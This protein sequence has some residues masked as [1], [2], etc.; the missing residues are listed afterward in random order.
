M[1]YLASWTQRGRD[2]I[3][4]VA[5]RPRPEIALAWQLTVGGQLVDDAWQVF[6]ELR[7]QV[8]LRCTC[9]AREIVDSLLAK[10]LTELRGRYRLVFPCAD[11]RFDH[12][13]KAVLLELI[14]EHIEAA[15][16]ILLPGGRRGHLPG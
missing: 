16:W 9:L 1:Y 8:I 5:P 6:G 13:L 2:D 12:T 7:K 14:D 10:S 11:P 15:G 4:S 3:G